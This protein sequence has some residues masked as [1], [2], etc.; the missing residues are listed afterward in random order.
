MNPREI[1][2][3][4][5]RHPA[6]RLPGAPARPGR[7]AD[8]ALVGIDQVKAKLRD[9][10]RT[11]GDEPPP[12]LPARAVQADAFPA[13]QI[14]GTRAIVEHRSRRQGDSR[15]IDRAGRSSGLTYASGRKSSA[16]CLRAQAE[17]HF[18]ATAR[19]FRPV[20]TAA[21]GSRPTLAR[22]VAPTSTRAS[23]APDPATSR[24]ARHPGAARLIPPNANG[25]QE[26]LSPIQPFRR[27]MPA[28]DRPAQPSAD[29]R[30]AEI[31]P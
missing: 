12:Q 25:R 21:A 23:D 2:A 3:R 20:E 29:T 5:V 14:S 26:I 13:G 4:L 24:P 30:P 17:A 11:L 16:P 22:P 1:S 7:P 28:S 6:Q 19:C 10:I 9:L 27:M 31:R 15:P 18:M 8:A